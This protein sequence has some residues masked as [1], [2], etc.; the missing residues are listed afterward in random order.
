MG[1][2]YFAETFW[3]VDYRHGKY[4]LDGA[5]AIDEV[6]AGRLSLGALP[7]DF[8]EALYV[9][10]EPRGLT[11]PRGRYAFMVGIGTFEA[12]NFRLRQYFLA[13]TQDER[14]ML[15]AVFELFERKKLMVTYNGRRFDVPRLKTRFALTGL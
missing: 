5:F 10:I 6:A 2:L 13:D 7:N 15:E 4:A 3:P 8:Q 11:S 14:V 12:F 9:D 1:Q